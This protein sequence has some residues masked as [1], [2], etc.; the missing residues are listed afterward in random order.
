MNKLLFLIK[1]WFQPTVF[2]DDV[3][4]TDQAHLTYTLGLY[5]MLAL[6]I[7]AVILVPLFVVQKI[8]TWT[9]IGILL[10]V[11]FIAR[12]LT[13]Q[14]K[15]DTAGI[16]VVASA[17]IVFEG[18]S[19]VAG[20]I[21]SPML[22]AVFAATII[23]SLLFKAR[24]GNLFVLASLLTGLGIAVLQQIGFVLPAY[25][26]FQPIATWFLFAL[27]LGF[28]NSTMNLVVRKLENALTFARQQGEARQQAEQ[29]LRHSEERFQMFMQ[30][31]PGLAYMKDSEMRNLFAN[32]GFKTYLGID[33]NEIIG[34]TNTAIFGPEFGEKINRDD[35]RVLDAGTSQPV[36]EEFGGKT[37]MTFKFCI[38]HPGAK[39]LLGGITLDITERK[40]A[41]Q[42][43][44]E[45]EACLHLSIDNMLEGYGLHEAILDPQG[46]MVDYRFLEFNPSAQKISNMDDGASII[47]KTA[48]ELYPHLVERG[49]MERYAEVMATG[50]SVRLDDFYY[51][52]DKL[53]KALDIA[54]FRIDD[55]HFACTF[56]DITEHK[57]IENALRESEAL[58]RVAFENTLVGM[59]FTSLT[60]KLLRV[61]D[62][63]C[64]TLG[65]SQD[66]LQQ[67]EFGTLT[68]PDDRAL[69]Y[70]YLQRMLRGEQRTCRFEKRYLHKNGQVVWA[71]IGVSL[72]YG[73]KGEPLHFITYTQDISERKRAEQALRE[74]ENR[75]RRMVE[76]SSDIITILNPDGTARYE[77]PAHEHL[78]G[79]TSEEMIG[80]YPMALVHPDDLPRLAQIF[81]QG[82]DQPGYVAKA[83]YR[84]RHKDGSWREI[85][86]LACNLIDDPAIKGILI[87]SRNIT[88]RK[89]AEALVLIR[90]RLMEIAETSSLSELLQKTLDE[91]EALTQSRIGF[92]H[93]VEA[94]QTTLSL[95]A[96]STRT[97]KEFCTAQGK[98]LHYSVADAG[99]WADCVYQRSP[100]IHNDY[101]SLAHRKGMPEGH[102]Q[103]VRELVVPILRKDLVVAILGVGNKLSDY[104]EKDVSIVSYLADVAWEIADRK[105]AEEALHASTAKLETL[106]QVSPLAIMLLDSDGNVQLWNPSAE[107]IFGW[108][109]PEVLGQPNPI[110]P[111]NKQNEYRT[112]SAQ[113]SQGK[114]LTNQEVVR[115]R[116]DGSLVEVSISSAPLHDLDGMVAGRMAI[117]AD[118]TERKRVEEQLV[119]LNECMLNFGID[120]LENIN[121]LAALGGELLNADCALYNRLDQGML[122][123][124]GQWHTPPGYN[125]QDKP[126]GHICYDVIKLGSDKPFIVR[127]LPETPYA[128]SDPNVVPY[129]LQTYVGQVV[130]FDNHNVGSLCMVYQRDYVPTE[131]QQRLMGIIASAIGVE[132]R[133]K[134]A[135]QAL[136]ESE[137]KYRELFQ[138]NKDG[139]AIFLLNSHG[140]PSTFVE[141]NDA[142]P[143]MLGYTREEMLDLTPVMLEPGVSR[144]KFQIRQAELESN[145]V[146]NFETILRH[147]NGQ[148]VFTEF[149]AQLIHYEGKPAIMN[150]VRD[151]TARK[152]AEAQ[153]IQHTERLATLNRIA[154]A[155]STT[156]NLD[157]LLEI[158]YQQI[159]ALIPSDAFFVALYN[160]ATTEIDYRI[161]V[162][163]GV[164]E[165][166]QRGRLMPGLTESIITSKQPLLICDFVQEKPHLRVARL[167]G[168]QQLPVSWLGAPM[169]LG[170]NV[171]GVISLQAYH[172]N[173]FGDTELELLTTVA[174]TVAV[175][176]E[177][178][179][180]YATAQRRLDHTEA[181][182]TIDTA[183]SSNLDLSDTL[184][185]LLQQVRAQL[186]VDAADVLVLNPQT[187]LLDYARGIGFQTPALV[188]THLHLGEGLAGRAASECKTLAI[189]DLHRDINGLA[190][191]PFIHEEG[192]VTY[193]GVPLIVQGRVNGVLEIFQRAPIEPAR[194]WT[195]FL[196][197]LAGQAAIA[198]D[199]ATLF[200]NL[201]HA[202][203]KLT[204]AY[205]TTLEGW[206]SALEL[207]EHET[208][209]HSERVVEL[210]LTLAQKL[211]VSGEQLQ[212]LRRGALLHDIGKMGI[213]DSILL[214]PGTLN[215]RE[216]EIMRRH[217]EYAYQLL[218]PI[219]YLHPAIEIPYCHHEKWDGTG[220]PRGLKGEDIPLSARLFAIVDVWDALRSGRPYRTAWDQA[221]VFE[222]IRT[223]A[224]IH[225][226]P[227]V[228]ELFF[229]VIMQATPKCE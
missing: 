221:K 165:P 166:V 29:A 198:I 78:L 99:V 149:T 157:D 175:A 84:I 123:S 67:V 37:W 24:I 28:T 9:I 139:I 39:P 4:K 188:H 1:R 228:V 203:T 117:I 158:V 104:D 51:L 128:E 38:N 109:A 156:L 170:D 21:D 216:W 93:F 35:Q 172:P 55:H 85:E 44:R 111:V 179:R 183:I 211:G 222:H 17:W 26:S 215:E 45:S 14:G 33:P 205:D 86:S 200:C 54:C 125:P 122:C 114:A 189:T 42:A 132:E 10:M 74:N 164:R 160:H 134:Q 182:H 57:R 176:V 70:E 32:A 62:A 59:V 2:P 169:L 95:Q 94:D 186:R 124:W 127:H 58:F 199:H 195:S 140:P 142:A 12:Y 171:I 224:G 147:K 27:A 105:R 98:G 108:N 13:R 47:G 97:A 64:Q 7:A 146:A 130:K 129:Q 106:I 87:N 207:R 220:Y 185:V 43:L 131:D 72:L 148:P 91:V 31:F 90:M 150:I 191:S 143:A 229:Q 8:A 154:R 20:G 194:E 6:I 23:I 81:M 135:E 53:D 137:K 60:G 46:R 180:L 63:F 121:R 218:E 184:D 25:F 153:A 178:A 217:P 16:L 118:I 61:N 103:V 168:T 5:F 214:K 88:D 22:F 50:E 161:R 159:T 138:V 210:T 102:A 141:L 41:E 89:Q 190:R 3:A 110:V 223:Q 113:V 11:Y 167:W 173:A 65:Y 192:F 73:T 152:Q 181:L 119:K 226:D 66:E 19:I 145:G 79:Y 116:K 15:R 77:S 92:Y 34:K 115:Q 100:I 151:I 18:M 206:S 202:N 112:L 56:R 209:G 133:R 36:E 69:S 82:I 162:D 144:E 219:D 187:Q 201:Q 174:D 30:Y 208:A 83:E 204:L 177:N 48:L 68:H 101:A 120:P 75:F 126:D 225:F 76:R 155:I 136:A 40:R 96:W 197:T 71:D 107:R 80:E 49:L 163:Q 213:P 227:R 212:H 196:E 193:Y 52:G